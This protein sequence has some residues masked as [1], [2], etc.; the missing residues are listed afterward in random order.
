MFNVVT[1]FIE[2]SSVA[3]ILNVAHYA[4]SHALHHPLPIIAA[5]FAAQ[6][7][8]AAAFPTADIRQVAN[9]ACFGTISSFSVI[10]A[11]PYFPS[12]K[13]IIWAHHCHKEISLDP[14][15]CNT[16][17][18][19]SA[20][21][22]HGYRDGKTPT[23]LLRSIAYPTCTGMSSSMH[24][25]FSEWHEAFVSDQLSSRGDELI[26]QMEEIRFPGQ[27]KEIEEASNQ[28]LSDKE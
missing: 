26:M 10:L 5:I 23:E 2:N 18:N 7:P 13:K 24:D 12:V 1:N 9:E 27:M 4:V 16:F 3:P 11:P 22:E 20:F 15:F 17:R 25:V 21:L 14:L 6:V 19:T 8:V 28:P